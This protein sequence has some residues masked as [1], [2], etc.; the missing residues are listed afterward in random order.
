MSDILENFLPARLPIAGL[1]AYGLYARHG[2]VAAECLSKSLYPV[3]TEQ[4]L[5]RVVQGGR[6]LLP[7]G[8][9][10]AQYCWT[11]EAHRLYVASRADGASLAL[12]VENN[13]NAQITRIKETLQD[14]LDLTEL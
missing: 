10:A 9:S 4:M 5:T 14:F 3:S 12:L 2:A 11:F 1:A 6:A 13:P 7:C 8:Q